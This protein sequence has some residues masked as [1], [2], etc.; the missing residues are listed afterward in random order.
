MSKTTKSAWWA[1]QGPDSCAYC[2]ASY[3]AETG[4]YCELCDSAICSVCVIT[5]FEP[6]R[7]ICPQCYQLEQS[8][9]V[10]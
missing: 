3:Y 6:S 1:H 9:G 7:V 5:E 2:E 4:Y 10:K 8:K